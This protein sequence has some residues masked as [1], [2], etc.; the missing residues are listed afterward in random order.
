MMNIDKAALLAKSLNFPDWATHVAA[1]RDGSKVEPA[2]FDLNSSEYLD[3]ELDLTEKWQSCFS[4]KYWEFFGI[5][6]LRQ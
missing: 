2:V 3:E 4:R 6:E 1:R 5:A